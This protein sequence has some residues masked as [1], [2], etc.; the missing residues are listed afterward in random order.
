MNDCNHPNCYGEPCKKLTPEEL[1]A[2]P[3]DLVIVDTVMRDGWQQVSAKYRLVMRW[4]A[5]PPKIAD[6]IKPEY[7]DTYFA[8]QIRGYYDLR[9]A[10]DDLTESMT[11]TPA[12]WKAF[13]KAQRE[14]YNR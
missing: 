12:Q 7:A 3:D 6:M 11:L 4:K 1:E 2:T 9:M 10:P 14:S 5:P 8:T 13:K